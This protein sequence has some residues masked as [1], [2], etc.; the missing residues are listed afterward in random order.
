MISHLTARRARHDDGWNGRVCQKPECNSYCI[1]A[2]SFPSDV[3]LR[4]RKLA[5]E[6]KNAGKRIA[7]SAMRSSPRRLRA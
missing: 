1:G 5:I 2:Q 7:E 6:K 3:G 4:E